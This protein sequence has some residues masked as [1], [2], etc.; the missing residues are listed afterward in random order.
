MGVIALLDCFIHVHGH[1]FTTDSNSGQLATE[2]A[3]L[4]KTTFGSAGWTELHG[5]LKSWT[6]ALKGFWQSDTSDAVD[7]E[8]F[9][10]LGSTGQVFTLGPV[11]TE[12]QVAYFAQGGKFNYQLLGQLGELAPF[13]LA[14]Q[15][16]SGQ[17]VIRGQLAKARGVV[18]AA[19]QVGSAL[20]L[21]AGAAGKFLYATVHTFLAGTTVTIQVQSDTASNFPTP[22]TVA[23]FPAITARG[24]SWLVRVDSTGITDTWWRLNVSAITGSF[25]VAGAIGIQ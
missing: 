8:I 13:T 6:L 3:P 22:T 16:T 19:G 14:S 17:G 24:A 18:S 25:T 12:A 7:P 15:G 2:T 5:G 23:T 1:D 10:G 21:G 4:D 9:N 11:E 20:N